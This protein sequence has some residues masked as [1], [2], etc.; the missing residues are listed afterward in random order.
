MSSATATSNRL[1]A[2]G[3]KP[4]QAQ[5]HM[6]SLLGKL[7][8]RNQFHANKEM[9]K[10]P[11]STTGDKLAK[12]MGSIQG[13]IANRI[14][15]MAEKPTAA[16]PKSLNWSDEN[17]Q[18]Q[19]FYSFLRNQ[20]ASGGLAFKLCEALLMEADQKIH[21]I[22]Q[23]APHYDVDAQQMA[24]ML[25]LREDIGKVV[26]AADYMPAKAAGIDP[27]K[28]TDSMRMIEMTVYTEMYDIYQRL[29]SKNN[30]ANAFRLQDTDMVHFIEK[31]KEIAKLLL[32]SQGH[33]NLGLIGEIKAHF[34]SGS[35]LLLEYEQ[36]IQYVM[37]QMDCSWQEAI[38]AVQPPSSGQFAS[39]A[40][41]RADLGLMPNE[42]ITK[43]HCQQ[44][45]LSALLS[46]LCQ[47][48]VG[49]CF[50]VAWAIKKHN[51]FLLDSMADYTAIVRDGFLARNVNGAQD[52]FFFETTIADEGM[53]E[54]FTLQGD[55]KIDEYKGAY[56]YECPNLVAACRQMGISDLKSRAN[57]VM[58]QIYNT[59][60]TMTWDRLIQ[61]CA[62]VF[63]DANHPQEELTLLGRYGF[64]LSNNRLLRA[65]ETSLAAMAE[66]RPNDYVRD[67]VSSAVMTVFKPIFESREK[68]STSYQKTLI[69]E[70]KK[71]FQKTLN[72]SFRLVYN[73][74]IPLQQ[75]S[76]DGSSSSGGFELY[77][78]DVRNLNNKGIRIATPEQ[79]RNFI[80]DILDQTTQAQISK[81]PSKK[82]RQVIL[83]VTDSL[84]LCAH[85]NT[86]MRDII[87]AYD[88]V[89][90]NERDPVAN[91]LNLERTPM[92]S[93]DG[94]NPW[95]V[96]AIDTGK[97]FTP[98]VKTIKPKDPGALLKWLLGLAQWKE[99]TEKY[100][101][102]KTPEDEDPA[103]SPQHAFNIE[104]K[105]EEFK[106]FLASGLDPDAWI[107]KTLI[108]PGLQVSRTEVDNGTKK[109]MQ[110]KAAHWLSRQ[111]KKGIPDSVQHETD[112]LF[113]S[114]NSKIVTVQQYAQ[115]LQDGIVKIFKL[116][117]DQTTSLSFALDNMLIQS[118]P[119][120]QS[121]ALQSEAFRF[122]RT[123]WDTGPKNL[124][125]CCYF[126]PR[127]EKVD[128][129]DIAEDRTVLE[130]MDQYEWIDNKE[131]EVDPSLI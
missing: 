48:P 64:S 51:E 125:F 83:S 62:E 126:N 38:D 8:E 28:L 77:Q 49:D 127:T 55:G 121:Q 85:A 104:F 9:Q 112:T 93:L 114:L 11:A 41:V 84:K 6:Q 31:P 39:N 26:F 33:I 57:D 108:E 15:K 118:L 101:E 128:F 107:Q 131:W 105:N 88:Q 63:A 10:A 2:G 4:A 68:K 7:I 86:F 19:T 90:K 66:D 43:L 50:A 78:R 117:A 3:I 58:T 16:E 119:K 80:F 35:T 30:A 123:N 34:F 44:V 37:D 70:T 82:D 40:I 122:A 12:L 53:D 27:A 72:D 120:A 17:I 47:G 65:W 89:N 100:L 14:A 42:A 23:T 124:F 56:F 20:T 52:D 24:V 1:L 21:Q 95:E 22:L 99:S 74:A 69:E 81:T 73:G 32:T 61:I 109:L 60:Q 91:Y 92:T 25:K 13:T 130:P 106:A 116:N 115:R 103:T 98:D 102:K 113:K 75:V 54:S 46:Q 59:K 76:S 94:D 29:V 79:F 110:Q 111:F 129:A 36:G 96:M 45:V 5:D 71:I 87:W 97:D 67:N 18:L